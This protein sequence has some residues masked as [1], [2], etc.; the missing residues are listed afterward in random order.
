MN[1]F[2]R[3]GVMLEYVLFCC[4]LVNIIFYCLFIEE[5]GFCL[6]HCQMLGGL[7]LISNLCG[8]CLKGACISVLS[9][10]FNQKFGLL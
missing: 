3:L 8:Y 9:D 5:H 6:V 2:L 10:V 4:E 1:C 7:E